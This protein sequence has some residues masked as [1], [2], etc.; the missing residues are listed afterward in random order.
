MWLPGADLSGVDLTGRELHDGYLADT[1]LD[2]ARLVGADLAAAFLAGAS[3]VGADLVGAHLAKATLDEVS[4]QGARFAE[5]NLLRCQFRGADLKGAVLDGARMLKTVLAQADLRSCSLR[6]AD[7][8]RSF[9]DDATLGDVDVT[10]A[11]ICFVRAGA[12]S[13]RRRALCRPP[14]KTWRRTCGT[15]ERSR[16]PSSSLA[17]GLVPDRRDQPTAERRPTDRKPTAAARPQH[18]GSSHT[19]RGDLAGHGVHKAPAQLDGGQ[20][21]DDGPGDA[22][23]SAGLVAHDQVEQREG[24]G[25][26]D[27]PCPADGRQQGAG[28]DEHDDAHRGQS[29]SRATT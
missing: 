1:V 5:A 9:I 8:D 11:S 19:A 3:L 28:D 24:D 22:E 14:P 15:R 20:S 29:R 10:G 6:H 25:S 2:D 13:P 18:M 27:D 23:A 17:A 4:A 21:T 16:S 26:G 7:L 12:L